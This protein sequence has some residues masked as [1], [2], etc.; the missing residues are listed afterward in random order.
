MISDEAKKAAAILVCILV[1]LFLIKP[2]PFFE[3][4]GDLSQKQHSPFNMWTLVTCL[5]MVIFFF[6]VASQ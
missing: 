5:S 3:P 6:V 4:E 2:H 1:L